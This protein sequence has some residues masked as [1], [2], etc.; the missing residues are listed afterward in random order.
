[1]DRV[2]IFPWIKAPWFN[3]QVEGRGSPKQA[4][5]FKQYPF[6]NKWNGKQN[7]PIY[8]IQKKSQNN[9]TYHLKEL[10]KEQ[11]QKLAEERK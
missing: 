2:W 8:V 9:L 10:E 3:I 5:L 6:R 11:S 1:M 7:F 4:I